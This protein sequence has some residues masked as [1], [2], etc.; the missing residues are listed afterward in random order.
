MAQTLQKTQMPRTKLG[1]S[2]RSDR[3]QSVLM[4]LVLVILALLTLLPIY[5]IF[6]ASFKPGGMLVQYGL[7]LDLDFSVMNFDNYKLL[8]SNSSNYWIWFR[9]SLIL[10]VISVVC[11][12]F[13]SSFVA[14]GF[15][16]YEFRFKQPLFMVVLLILSVPFEVIMLPLYKQ[17]GQWGLMDNYVAI[18]LPFVANASTIFFFR[19][20]LIG[21]PK[22]L[23]EAGRVDGATEYGIFFRLI[24]P[25]MKP[26]FAAMAILNGMSA[27]NNYLWPLLVISSAKKY[28]LTLG[29]NT[30]LTPYG[31]NYSLL[32]VGSF[33]SIIP[34]FILFVCFQKYFIEGMTAGAVKG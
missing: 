5:A 21:L 9:N 2:R 22:E 25:I 13:I 33:F 23:I 8:F 17:M 26:A 6:L 4:H 34:V 1:S 24:V 16:A 32:L 30:L 31:N 12:L 29:L 10:T 11:T 14:Y 7:N 27:W 19:Q 20:Y 15:A 28:T 3:I 18:I